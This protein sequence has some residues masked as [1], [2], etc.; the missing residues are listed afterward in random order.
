M[1]IE[2]KMQTADY[3][4]LNWIVLSP[5]SL[6]TNRK[7]ANQSVI[8]TWVIFKLTGVQTST[9]ISLNNTIYG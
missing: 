4:L 3:R 8:L 7:Q 6:R 9:T 2:G 5:L 1:Q